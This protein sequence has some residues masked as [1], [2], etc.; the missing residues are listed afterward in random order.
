MMINKPTRLRSILVAVLLV[1]MPAQPLLASVAILNVQPGPG[2]KP[3]IRS[4]TK[5]TV[6][7][8]RFETHEKEIQQVLLSDGTSL[9]LGPGSALVIESFTYDPQTQSGQLNVRLERGQFR[10]V[11]G[12]LNN[13]GNIA[14]Q[15]PSGKLDLDNASAFVEVQSNGATRAS[16]LH[17]KSLKMTTNGKSETVERP[18][19][20][21]V[22]AGANQPIKS[23]SHQDPKMVAADAL[24][25]NSQSL[26]DE[27]GGGGVG[28]PGGQGTAVLASLSATGSERPFN[29]GLT[30]NNNPDT[31]NGSTTPPGNGS[32]TPPGNGSTTPPGNG[33]GPFQRPGK[34]NTGLNSS[35]GF[36]TGPEANAPN[37][38][39]DQPSQ[40][41]NDRRSL[42]QVRENATVDANG[43]NFSEKTRERGR[44][45]NRLFNSVGNMAKPATTVS[46]DPFTQVLGD[47]K[48]MPLGDN[49]DPSDSPDVPIEK[50][51]P[52][53]KL[54]YVFFNDV[55]FDRLGLSLAIDGVGINLDGA[56]VRDPR[57]DF[58]EVV[59]PFLLLGIQLPQPNKIFKK[60]IKTMVGDQNF[61]TDM[62]SIF[63]EATHFEILQAGFSQEVVEVDDDNIPLVNV[64]RDADNFLLVEVRP[65]EIV[66]GEPELDLT[67]TERY[68]FATGDVDGGRLLVDGKPNPNFKSEFS[69]DRYFISPG[70]AGFE[71]GFTTDAAGKVVSTGN[72][73]ASSIRTFLRNETK[74]GMPLTDTGLYVINPKSSDPESD[75]TL[76]HADFGLDGNGASQK[77]TISVTLG[78]V[79]YKLVVGCPSNDGCDTT[80][81]PKS[82]E[83][84]ISGRTIGSSRDN[85]DRNAQTGLANASIL[86]SSRL[87]STAAGGG[88]PL[89]PVQGRAGYFVLE[90]VDPDN[91]DFT[92]GDPNSG[93]FEKPLDTSGGKS[94]IQYAYLRLAT[95]TGSSQPTLRSELTLNGWMGGLAE[96]QN[97]GNIGIAQID[98]GETPDNIK[99]QTSPTNNTVAANFTL[100]GQI[101]NQ[102]TT[103]NLGGLNVNGTSAF[104]DDNRFAARS[105][106]NGSEVAMV[107]ADLFR[108]ATTG[109]LPAS[110]NLPDG[111]SIQKYEHLKWG[112]FFGDTKTNAGAREHVNLGT[113]IAGKIL[114]VDQVKALRGQASYTGHSIGNVF[115]NGSLYT[116]V[117][118]FT[119]QWDF[120]KRTGEVQMKF[121]QIAYTGK[122]AIK[123]NSNT[124]TGNLSATS[125]PARSGGL[126][127]SFV[128][129]ANPTPAA[130]MGNFAI[131]EQP[132]NATYRA[133]GTFGAERK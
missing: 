78:K 35:D 109:T 105:T 123:N 98:S 61:V 22:S 118:S 30:I 14:I 103:F 15:T 69:V 18:A 51:A 24:A 20:E 68:L 13:T 1:L 110:L 54:Q 124:F 114:D 95:A 3:T 74:L 111:S 2:G 104:A 59:A 86:F 66:G 25:L 46:R 102:F 76:L 43:D 70:L 9:T 72:T 81:P 101:E 73:V 29:T 90:N 75:A 126:Q 57:G 87:D 12:L 21:V 125:T 33:G 127:G 48:P 41:N 44:T 50:K 49:A 132:G 99:I 5:E 58:F 6:T 116:A 67:R 129:P 45:T 94:D 16:L 28:D 117:G 119:N 63:K 113:W 10:V 84:V 65:G 133:A 83:A 23:P 34:I 17:G 42:A 80:N 8:D 89:L 97:G 4:V 93:G 32:T 92:I 56:H 27:Q 122:T 64:K 100:Q 38:S 40:K 77:S 115:N 60:D 53:T 71:D 85:T 37:I 91:P 106:N 112:F 88:N 26:L 11:G 128:A 47:Q 96:F 36:G 108:D 55:G 52:D 19:F 131:A 7:G 107:T 31:G 82:Y 79:D 39:T 130:V 120:N 62:G 121:D